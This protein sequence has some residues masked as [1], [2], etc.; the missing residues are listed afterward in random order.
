MADSKVPLLDGEN[1]DLN[2]MTRPLQ[3]ASSTTSIGDSADQ[4]KKYPLSHAL[5]IME[6]MSPLLR[7]LAVFGVHFNKSSQ[8]S[9]CSKVHMYFIIISSAL[10]S[11]YWISIFFTESSGNDNRSSVSFQVD[12]RVFDP[13]IQ[14]IGILFYFLFAR[15]F[16][17]IGHVN[18]SK[19]CATLFDHRSE[20]I[21]R[22]TRLDFAQQLRRRYVP[23]L[24]VIVVVPL[25]VILIQIIVN[26]QIQSHQSFTAFQIVAFVANTISIVF[27]SAAI[28]SSFFALLILLQP[29]ILAVQALT[30]TFENPL[31]FESLKQN[32][33]SINP[34]DDPQDPYLF[35]LETIQRNRTH[36]ATINEIASS[37]MAVYFVYISCSYACLVYNSLRFQFATS[38]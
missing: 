9:T 4:I 18:L 38:L 5:D 24:L 20:I 7:V 37:S 19:L 25:V 15:I 36:L 35:G 14:L 12:S 22:S 10:A 31:S 1:N 13:L 33:A 29:H 11:F 26:S 6:C 2:A 8:Q 3:T 28:T 32:L 23:A 16:C 30:E 21:V 34:T 27:A 17:T